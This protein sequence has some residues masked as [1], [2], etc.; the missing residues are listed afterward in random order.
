MIARPSRVRTRVPHPFGHSLQ[1]LAYHV[2]MPGIA[3]SGGVTYGMIFSGG[4][5]EHAEIAA[6]G[7]A[8]P[9]TLRKVRRSTV[10]VRVDNDFVVT[11]IVL[12]SGRLDNLLG[13]HARCGSQDTIPWRGIPLVEQFPYFSH[14]RDSSRNRFQRGRGPCA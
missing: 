8:L 1:T 12:S 11:V 4:T 9:R 5:G 2:A 7:P 13:L 6:A 3:S 10:S 14:L